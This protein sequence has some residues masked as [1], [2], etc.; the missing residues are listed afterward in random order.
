[1]RIVDG[2]GSI[3]G[4]SGDDKL[5]R[6]RGAAGRRSTR[7]KEVSWLAWLVKPR[8][9]GLTI[10]SITIATVVSA[11]ISFSSRSVRP[12]SVGRCAASFRA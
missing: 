1:M 7:D 9:N 3:G 2:E 12:G 8:Q 11:G 4:W 10:T 5:E 6:G